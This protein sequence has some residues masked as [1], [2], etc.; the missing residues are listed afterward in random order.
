MRMI[1]ND[2]FLNVTEEEKKISKETCFS[3]VDF[4]TL[5]L[6]TYKKYKNFTCYLPIYYY[7]ANDIHVVSL[8]CV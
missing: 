8:R 5:H 2:S 4:M 7:Y 3:I 1:S 6:N